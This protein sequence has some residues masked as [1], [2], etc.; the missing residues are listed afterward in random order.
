M[1]EAP[2]FR[3]RAEEREFWDKTDLSELFEEGEWQA[4]EWTPREDR[5]GQ[6]GSLMQLR[7]ID[8]HLANDLVTLHRVRLYVCPTCQR[9][10][11]APEIETLA[12]EIEA[13]V[14]R[15]ISQKQPA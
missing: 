10:K 1:K 6:C 3:T 11:L 15:A 14:Q 2:P 8:L 12:K 13:S 5:C 7:S 4:L 9:T